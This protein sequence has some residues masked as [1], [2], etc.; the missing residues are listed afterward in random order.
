MSKAFVADSSVGVAWAVLSQSSEATDRLLNDVASGT[1]FVVPV[2]WMFEVANA[3]LLLSRRK[4]IEPEQ[5]ARA[6]RAVSRLAPLVD[7]EGPQLAWSRIW[8]LADRHA[9]S[10]YDAV[11]LELAVRRG[12][13]LASRDA[14]LN[15]AAKLSGVHTLL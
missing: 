9:L 2:L 8:E 13:P 3:L 1:P 12:L 6:R 5:C 7:E 10:E 11:Y 15:K 14:N 4:R